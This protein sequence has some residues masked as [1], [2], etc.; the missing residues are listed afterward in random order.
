[1]SRLDQWF[2]WCFNFFIFLLCFQLGMLLFLRSLYYK[3]EQKLK[4]NEASVSFSC[5]D[6]DKEESYWRIQPSLQPLHETC[7]D[8]ECPESLWVGKTKNEQEELHVLSVVRPQPTRK[9]NGK[10][11]YGHFVDVE[12]KK[13][14]KPI[15]LVLINQSLMQ[16]NIKADEE[17]QIKK[18]IVASPEIVWVDG[19]KEETP[20][21]YFPREKLCAYPYAWEEFSNP[22]NEY[23]RLAKALQQYTGLE[24]DSF[25]G[26]QVGQYFRLPVTTRMEQKE[27]RQPSSVKV[28]PLSLGLQ[29]QRREKFLIAKDFRFHNKNDQQVQKVNVPEKTQDAIFDE[30]GEKLYLIKGFRFGVWD[31]EQE[32]FKAILLPLK[33][34]SMN[35]PTSMAYDSVQRKIFVYN[36]DRGGEIYVYDI[37]AKQWTYQKKAVGYSLTAL[38]YIEKENMIYGT[39]VQGNKV[40]EVLKID[41]N[42]KVMGQVS[43]EKPFQYSKTL[44]RMQMVAEPNELWLKVVH[45]AHP[46][47][48]VYPLSQIKVAL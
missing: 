44:W 24:I 38:A 41:Q 7:L 42:G 9:E 34:P 31:W 22:E 23:R 3:A 30:K 47:G 16:W 28:S 35:W 17:A 15:T 46:G 26:R 4:D 19:L 39:R 32:E 14:D 27:S 11:V 18:V 37:A 12:I 29:W 5:G 21:V 25:Q 6:F 45:P 8:K 48:D 10:T 20:L 1:M 2:R 13:T 40:I 36:E 43:L 33:L